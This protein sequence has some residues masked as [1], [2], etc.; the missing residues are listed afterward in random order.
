MLKFIFRKML[1]K[2]WMT[3]SLLV[4]NLLMVAIAA[5]VPMYSQAVLQRTFTQDM[6]RY[7]A[8]TNTYPGIVH[9]WSYRIVNDKNKVE[10]IQ[11]AEELFSGLVEELDVPTLVTVTEFSKQKVKAI[12]DVLLETRDN[13]LSIEL[14][15]YTDLEEHIKISYG[16]MF[17]DTAE[18]N[19]VEVIV[20]EKTFI[21][22]NYMLGEELTLPSLIAKDGKPYKIRIV[23]IFENKEEQDPYWLSAPSYWSG[24]YLMDKELFGEL[25]AVVENGYLH[26][27]KAWHAVLDYQQLDADRA[28]EMLDI[29]ARY[30]KEYDAIDVYL[31]VNFT[32]SLH[33]F[34]AEAQKLNAT[35]LVLQVPVFLLLVAFIFMVSRQMLDME[36]NEISVFKS[37]GAGK[38]QIMQLYL[39]QSV[40]ISMI[41][42]V[43]GVPLGMLVCKVLGASN[44]FLE[45]VQRT[46][47]PVELGL[48]VWLFALAA[49]LISIGT[50]VLP[51][52]KH[53]NVNI[54]AHKRQKM[55]KSKKPW[56][57]LVFL[58][59]VL[60]VAA[61]YYW[62][63][64]KGQEDFIAQKVMDGASLD[65]LL[66]F[67][68]SL[69]ML[70]AGLFVLRL[71]PLMIR[72]VFWIGKRF[73]SPAIYASFLRIIRTNDNQ[74]FL[75]VFLVL[76][77]ALGVFNTQ[78]ART[79]NLNA[80][81]R[82]YYSTGADLVVQEEW[83]SNSQ[84]A[85][86]N[87]MGRIEIS[88]REP[89]FGK[90]REMDG[91]EQA[92]RVFVD[93]NI[94]VNLKEGKLY[95][96]KLMGIHTKEFGETAWFKESLLNRHWYEYL[97]A[98][99]QNSRAILV[100]SNFR[101]DYGY[102]VGDALTYV[103]KNGKS[104][105][106]VI[107]G[108]VDYW[109]SYAPTTMSKGAD[110]LYTQTE[111]YLIVAH[112]SQLQSDWGISPYQ[113]WIKTDGASGF[114]YDYALE[115]G[116]RYTVFKDASAELISLKNDPIFQGTN[117]ILTIGFIVVLLLCATGFLIY[118][119]LSIQS[120]TLQFGI[121][122][123]M[124][125]SGREVLSMLVNE[126]IFVSGVSIVAG[127]L[128][129]KIA[130]KLYVPLIQIAYSAAD[131][132]IPLEIISEAGDYVRLGVVVGF[133]IVVC[134]AVLGML[135]SKIKISQALKL[136]ED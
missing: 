117:G 60:I 119:I 126:Q 24:V 57:Q 17:S 131:K 47:L 14:S 10:S 99:S 134:M 100:S 109:P 107:Y 2:K 136:G 49:V 66:Y 39:L 34:I 84:T 104:E 15:C 32:D 102:E 20:N 81:D 33:S 124:G 95:N 28:E 59:I 69:F 97:N 45:F 9:A 98:M 7:L 123:A 11:K 110:G 96:V 44:A 83:S 103:N 86:E 122:R 75:V 5:A 23:G 65:P 64:F 43:G 41:G 30:Q 31:S 3:I 82:L 88:Y 114:L 74:G 115:S 62:Y 51:V 38:G 72:L 73:W 87:A 37:R 91:V 128:I 79:I 112:L 106:G 85:S 113:V 36:Q 133:M 58:D 70:G 68:S 67:S 13:E 116:T 54:V 125:M 1:N 29:I 77:M 27:N 132:V 35:I 6:G 18:N 12:P 71:L 21:E 93:E 89:D 4:G 129:G 127:V 40:V 121:F 19:T 55:R 101:D 76:T 80:E 25:F 48:K 90:Y 130:A 92:T 46:A 108:F 16:E 111:N 52:F 26:C 94:S 22:Q 118:W 53:A 105:K 8:E 135:I 50:M 120:R 78:T 42:F 56:W 61:V 63:Q